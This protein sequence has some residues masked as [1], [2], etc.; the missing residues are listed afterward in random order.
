MN[1]LIL[2]AVRFSLDTFKEEPGYLLDGARIAF[3]MRKHKLTIAGLAARTGFTQK[4]IREIRDTGLDNPN[5]ARDWIQAITG[6]DPG[7]IT[8]GF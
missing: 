7:P 5:A 8:K 4:R 3:L 6:E 1:S 2:R